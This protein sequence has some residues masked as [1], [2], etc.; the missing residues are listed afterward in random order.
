MSKNQDTNVYMREPIK[1][2]KDIPVFSESDD[3][4]RNYEAVAADHLQALA[5]DGVNPWIVE[6]DWVELE[7]STASLIRKYRQ[8]GDKILDVGIGLGRLTARFPELDR[9]G[10]DI[11][12]SYL[13]KAAEKG[14]KVC[15][16]KVEDMPY[17]HNFFD[18]V[19]CTDVLEHVLDLN[20]AIRQMLIVLKPGG[21]LI[22]RVPYREKLAHYLDKSYPYK[23]SH[24]RFF[25]EY[26]L[27]LLFTKV[28]NC[29]VM[30]SSYVLYM[31]LDYKLKYQFPVYR[32]NKIYMQL[33]Y[34][35]KHLNKRLHSY[36]MRK[37]FDSVCINFVVKKT[38]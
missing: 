7:E 26:S 11:S 10:M 25:D 22:V 17:T 37:S 15:Y 19:V 29:T 24:L 36:L 27:A 14:I 33:T 5:K 16:A 6:N 2:C 23:Y 1:Y 12:L 35:V 8:P 3:Y 21:Y 13:E 30:E 34:L 28:F 20:L 18:V 32:V 38:E 4:L 31:P 9:Y